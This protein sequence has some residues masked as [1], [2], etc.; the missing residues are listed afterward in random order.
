ML[1]KPI[2]WAGG[3]LSKEGGT[4]STANSLWLRFQPNH[5]L[6]DFLLQIGYNEAIPMKVRGPL[7]ARLFC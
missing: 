3:W 2:R 5:A 4:F 1:P 7:F 6:R